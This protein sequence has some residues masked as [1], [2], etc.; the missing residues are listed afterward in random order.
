MRMNEEYPGALPA[1]A[2]GEPETDLQTAEREPV[3]AVTPAG[4]KRR[5]HCLTVIGQIEGHY[6]LP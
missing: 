5:I 4:G 1:E 6:V 3:D 2:Q